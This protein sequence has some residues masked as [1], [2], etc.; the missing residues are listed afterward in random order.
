MD[1]K[2]RHETIND[3]PKTLHIRHLGWLSAYSHI[4]SKD[5][6]NKHFENKKND[7]EYRKKC[8]DRITNCKYFYVA[9]INDEVV[10]TMNMIEK[11]PEENFMELACLYVHPDYQRHGIGKMFFDLACNIAKSNNV[12]KLRIEALKNNTIGCSFYKKNG[13]VVVESRIRHCCDIDVENVTFEFDL[14]NTTLETERLLLR[15]YTESDLNDYFEYVGNNDV[16]SRIGFEAYQD[17]QAA[18]ERLIYEM[19]KPHQ[20]AIVLKNINK[21]VGSIELMNC[22]KDRY[23]TIEIEDNAKEIGFMLSPA[24]WGQGIVPEACKRIIEFVFTNTDAPCIYVSHAKSNSQSAR[25][26]DK[27]GF[28]IIGEIDNYRTWIDGKSTSLVMRKMTRKDWQNITNN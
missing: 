10:G 23:S 1:V 22:K 12:S 4:F 3:E 25:V 6:I 5:S 9:T 15:N 17:K 8:L 11:V 18:L 26:Q 19:Q 7:P 13:G 21:V 14:T 24:F 28:K 2:I 16:S 27:L 20:F